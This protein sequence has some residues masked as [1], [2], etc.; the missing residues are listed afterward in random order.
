MAEFTPQQKAVLASTARYNLVNAIGKTGK[1]TLLTR[2]YLNRQERPEE[3]KAV[4][5]TPNAYCT[6]RVIEQLGKIT[7]KDWSGQ[8]IGTLAE[9]SAKLLHRFYADLTYTR[10]PRIVSDTSMMEERQAARALAANLHPDQTSAAF[11]EQWNQEFVHRLRQLDIAT[12]RSLVIELTNMFT[13]LAHPN[14][15]N[16][17]LLLADNVHD[18][19]ID[20]MMALIA[21]QERM[22]QSFFS[23]NTNVAINNS[24]Q[25]TDIAN[26]I[27]IIS[28]EELKPHSLNT[29]FGVGPNQGL[30]LHQLSA[31]NTKK[32]YEAGPVFTGAQS[33]QTLSEVK[34][35]S[36]EQMVEVIHEME[37][38]LQLGIRNR[39]M[40]VIM[41]TIDEARAMAQTIERQC[42]FMWDKNK[43]WNPSDPPTKGTFVTTPYEAPYLNL[44]YIALPKCMDGYWPYE[45][46]RNA[47]KCRRLFI[48]S[49]SSARLGVIFLIPDSSNNALVS[50]FVLEGCNPKLVTKEAQFSTSRAA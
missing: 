10:V 12:P 18:L 38:Q 45:Q 41:R 4:F 5:V 16:V 11:I 1:T 42:F 26:W 29:C 14:L 47:E 21:I 30:F 27:N 44:D 35:P 6:R 7:S 50:P 13:K 20:E 33:A 9:I 40:G 19:T 48:R 39:S 25:D 28:R 31:F 24:S 32:L 34:V 36:M 43:L 2:L 17:H 23:G 15:A 3:F 8:L 46:E 22:A 49:V 37:S